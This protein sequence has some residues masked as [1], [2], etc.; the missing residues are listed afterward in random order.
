MENLFLLILGLF[1]SVCG[2]ANI[3]GNISTIHSYNRRKVREEDIPKYG[4]AM[5][6]GTLIIGASMVISF[7]TSF[8]SEE[9]TA[10]ILLLA[11]AAGLTFILYA[12]FKYN[13]GIF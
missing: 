3:T 5:G 10:F 13:K 8:W 12:Q 11:V 1:I 6:T 2:I 9:V 4:K 7:V